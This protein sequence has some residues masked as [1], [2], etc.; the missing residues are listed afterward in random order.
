MLIANIYN[1]YGN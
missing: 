1:K